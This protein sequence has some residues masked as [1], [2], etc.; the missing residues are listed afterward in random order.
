MKSCI[1]VIEKKNFFHFAWGK[2]FKWLFLS[3]HLSFIHESVMVPAVH[4]YQNRRTQRG[5]LSSEIIGVESNTTLS[6]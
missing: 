6:Y 1:G 4:P 5:D 3:Y 2:K